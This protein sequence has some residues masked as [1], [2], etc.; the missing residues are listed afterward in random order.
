MLTAA[1]ITSALGVS[2]KVVR[3]W[4]ATPYPLNFALTH[5]PRCGGRPSHCY[6]VVDLCTRLRLHNEHEHAATILKQTNNL[7][8]DLER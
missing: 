3:R 2:R 5:V 6:S 1:Q 8:E 7:G 4:L